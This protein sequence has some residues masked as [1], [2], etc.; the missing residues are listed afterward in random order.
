[1][2]IPADAG[3]RAAGDPDTGPGS[4]RAKNSRS[5]QSDFSD[6]IV[7]K[8]FSFRIMINDIKFLPGEAAD[9]TGLAFFVEFLFHQLRGQDKVAAFP[10]H[11]ED[12][13][14]LGQNQPAR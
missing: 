2:D 10:A 7:K 12:F 6:L 13:S 4:F 5:V 3:D 14:Q 11:A 8:I 1:M 9:N